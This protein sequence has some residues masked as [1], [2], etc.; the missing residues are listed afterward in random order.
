MNP[1][2]IE[3]I[4]GNIVNDFFGLYNCTNK[5]Y[6][7]ELHKLQSDAKLYINKCNNWS[8]LKQKNENNLYNKKNDIKNISRKVVKE[9]VFKK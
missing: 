9:Y 1:L 3:I 2:S 5:I 4:R 6:F 8:R 7:K